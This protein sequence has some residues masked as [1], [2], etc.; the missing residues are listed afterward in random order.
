MALIYALLFFFVVISFDKIKITPKSKGT[1]SYF[2]AVVLIVFLI[3]LYYI[4]YTPKAAN[5]NNLLAI[6]NWLNNFFNGIFPYSLRNTFSAYPFFYLIASPFYLIGNIALTEIL[7]WLI[8]AFF[9]IFTSVTV[10]EKTIK[11]FFLLVSP[12]TFYGLFEASGYFVNAVVIVI[13]ILLSNKYLNPG[14]VDS[15]FI[16]FAVVFGL[17]FSP[18]I[19]VI[20]VLVIYMLFF[21]KN[22]IKELSLFLEILLAVF[23]ITI[24]PFIVWNPLLF[25]INGPTS[26][27]FHFNFPWWGIILYLGIAVYIGW[28]ISDLQEI[29]FSIGVLLIIPPVINIFFVHTGLS[30]FVFALPFLIFSIKDYRVE[31][32]AGKILTD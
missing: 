14:N 6:K 4:F 32:F 18:S 24:L 29:F 11:L 22:N 16:L 30:G 5:S 23:L 3:L 2:I 28:I 21:F 25:F 8:L 19:E 17:Y 15:Y 13:L 20:V 12:L 7:V 1:N 26:S 10:R 27:I 31:K 9:V